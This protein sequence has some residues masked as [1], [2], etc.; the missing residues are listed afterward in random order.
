MLEELRQSWR[1][2]SCH[3]EYITETERGDRLLIINNG[4]IVA[5]GTPEALRRELYGGEMVRIVTNRPHPQSAAALEDL[6]YVVSV[7]Q[8]RPEEVELVVTSA[9]TA[10][11]RLLEEV[12]ARDYQIDEI[13]EVQ[14]SLDTLFVELVQRSSESNPD[15]PSD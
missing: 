2:R 14:V 5:N 3:D 7:E 6:D 9:N 11:P 12:Q 13:G 4:F 8:L 1:D 15:A 10:I